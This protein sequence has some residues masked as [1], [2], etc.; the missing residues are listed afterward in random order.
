MGET[1]TIRGY[2][3]V[4]NSPSTPLGNPP[5]VEQ[6]SPAAWSPEND[7]TDVI[8]TFDHDTK[9]YLGRRS[10]GTLRLGADQT[11]IWFECDLPDTAAGRDVFA[12]VQRGDISGCS[13]TFRADDD[14]WSKTADGTPLR[15]VTRMRVLELGPVL[16]PAYPDT[17]VAV[18]SMQSAGITPATASTE[19]SDSMNGIYPS[20]VT[21]VVTD[22]EANRSRDEIKVLGRSLSEVREKDWIDAEGSAYAPEILSAA[23]K[24]S[25]LIT[26][27]AVFPFNRQRGYVSIAP[28]VTAVLQP[29][30]EAAIFIENEVTAPDFRAVKVS[31]MVSV[32]KDTLADVPP[33]EAAINTS[34]AAA[35]GQ[36]IDNTLINGGTDGDVTVSGMLADGTATTVTAIG[37]DEITDAIA[38]VRDSGGE[39]TAVMGCPSAIAA[40]LKRVDSSK[41]DKIPEL[42]AIPDLADGTVGLPA[43]TVLVADLDSVAVAMRKNLEIYKTEYA[44]EAFER[45]RAFIAGRSRIGSVVLADPARVQ[46]LKVGA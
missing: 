23:G 8:C 28:K 17:T 27:V 19:E 46:V 36:R 22:D 32:D 37:F 42:I 3:I 33:T 11:G 45:D 26:K 6:I 21:G 41:L 29:R 15:T 16:N 44:P 4:F 9:N 2:G 39:A 1:L 38:R 31:A 40:I 34:L 35:I 24:G 13:F 5:F 7:E 20:G 25:K 10:A 18:R 12:L 30:N 14:E 43:G